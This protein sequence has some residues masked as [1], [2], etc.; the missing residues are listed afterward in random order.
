[1]MAWGAA[2]P[3]NVQRYTVQPFGEL[4]PRSNHTGI[5]RPEGCFQK[6]YITIMIARNEVTSPRALTLMQFLY[7]LKQ[8]PYT[9]LT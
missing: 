6:K 1:M 8:Q 7:E 2:G 3:H 4:D 9:F 5:D